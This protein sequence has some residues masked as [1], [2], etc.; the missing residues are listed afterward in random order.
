MSF[1]DVLS[2]QLTDL[3]RIGLLVAMVLTA[4]NTAGQLN[5][6]IPMA[7]GVVFVAVL[8]PLTMGGGTPDRMQAIGVG[9]VSNAIILAAILAAKAVYERMSKG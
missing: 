1:T 8:I 6:V 5:P 4:R 9:L 3:F 2:A 7:L